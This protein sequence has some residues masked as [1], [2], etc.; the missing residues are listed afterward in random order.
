MLKIFFGFLRDLDYTRL[1]DYFYLAFDNFVHRKIRSWLTL[2]GI[3][4][5]VTAVVSLISL[6]DGLKLA[7]TSQFG[8]S[9][10]E[11]ISVQAGGLS[12]GPPGS[13]AVTPLTKKDVDEIKKLP[14]VDFSVA[15]IVE[16]GKLEFD[17]KV[18][19][20]FATNFPDGNER[21]FLYDTLEFRAEK[22]RLLKDG[23]INKVILGNN[24]GE[25][26]VGF[27]KK[28]FPGDTISFKDESFEVVGILEKKGSF[29]F[30]NIVG[31]NAEPLEDLME[32]PDRVDVIAVKIKDKSLMDKA[33]L[34]IEK[35]LR[36]NR[37]VKEGQ[38]DFQVQTPQAALSTINDVLTGVQIFIVLIASISIFVG[39]V[40]I[41]NT[42]TTSVMERK[43]Q[44]GIMKSIGAKNSD[45]FFQF[46]IESGLMGFLGGLVGVILGELIAFVGTIGINSFIG[47]ES[48]FKLNFML[49]IL[50]LFGSFLIGA[51]SGIVPAVNAAR[52]NPVE[53]LRS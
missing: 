42:M 51:V 6:G 36:K 21:K 34:E 45:I 10:T 37:G 26:K 49:I 9:S 27:G 44:I 28:I 41:I 40:G 53:S 35:L 22:G 29:I 4:I 13:G 5:G 23:D 3:L 46:F 19:L 33:K 47:S 50:T 11:V 1:K 7:V 15:R 25:D 48:G 20:G 39:S 52:Q 12:F 32:N 30:D 18:S 14:S 24:F 16:Q 8:I 43:K 31:M 17:K 38:E 2:L